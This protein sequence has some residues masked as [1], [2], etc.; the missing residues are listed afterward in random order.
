M[1]DEGLYWFGVFIIL[2]VIVGLTCAYDATKCEGMTRGMGM[3]SDWGPI[4]GCLVQ[5]PDKR[6]IP[7]DNYRAVAP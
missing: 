6:W 4:K 1:S 3:K 5:L 2:V 7:L